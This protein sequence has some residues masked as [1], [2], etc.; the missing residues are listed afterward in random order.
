MGVVVAKLLQPKRRRKLSSQV[1]FEVRIEV[2][3]VD[4]DVDAHCLRLSKNSN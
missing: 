1:L 4:V 2:E 3:V